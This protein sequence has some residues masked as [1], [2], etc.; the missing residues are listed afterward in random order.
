MKCEEIREL[1]SLSIDQMLDDKEQKDVEEHLSVCEACQ[2][3][4]QDLLEIHLLLSSMEPIPVPE[5]F[6][7]RLKQALKEEKKRML[8]VGGM[9]QSIFSSRRYKMVASIAAVFVVGVLTLGVY[10]DVLGDMANKL[11]FESQSGTEQAAPGDEEFNLYGTLESNPLDDSADVGSL[12]ENNENRNQQLSLPEGQANQSD[13]Q[14][15]MKL[16]KGTDSASTSNREEAFSGYGATSIASAP[17]NSGSGGTVLK[18]QSENNADGNSI[19]SQDEYRIN[20]AEDSA[21]SDVVTDSGASKMKE[22]EVTYGI[23]SQDNEAKAKGSSAGDP[24]SRS[25]TSSGIERNAAAVKLYLGLIETKLEGF[26]YQVLNSCYVQTGQ[27]EFAVF[28]FRGKDGNT[29]N[30][31]IR[32]IGKDGKIE[33]ICSNEI[34]GL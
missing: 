1:L 26:D 22:Q 19:T 4:Y 3:E 25:L 5:E 10:Q 9:V 2:N 24:C 8:P 6:Q 18:Q 34:T 31:E 12:S 11:G 17:E 28:I 16:Y 30:E 14:K 20:V 21:L 33:I 7:L 23:L 15:Q 29:Y 32:I 13:E 27:W